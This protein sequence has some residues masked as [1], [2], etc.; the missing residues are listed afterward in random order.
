M[1]LTKEQDAPVLEGDQ[2]SP[3][4]KDF[5]S[6]CLQKDP[7]QRLSAQELLQHPFISS[8]EN[9]SILSDLITRYQNWKGLTKRRRSVRER[10]LDRR[11]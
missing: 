10:L 1:L 7:E 2:F 6:K 4:F 11:L 8:A 9:F 5:V 3:E